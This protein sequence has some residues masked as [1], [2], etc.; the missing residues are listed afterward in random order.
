MATSKRNDYEAG[1][2]WWE[3]TD[4][5]H[6]INRRQFMRQ[7]GT[8]AA[9][10]GLATAAPGFVGRAFAQSGAFPGLPGS[11]YDSDEEPNTLKQ[12]TNKNNFYELGVA[13]SQ[14]PRNIQGFT[15][16]PWEISIGG[17]IAKPGTFDVQDL[18]ARYRD[19]L[20]Q[21]IYRLRC[22]EKWAMVIPWVG[23]PLHELI[24]DYGPTSRAKYLRFE[25]FW[26][27]KQM[28][29]ARRGI[30]YPYIEGLRMDEAMHDLTLVT[31][32]MYGDI[33]DTAN[34]PP[35]RIIVPWKYGY[36]SIKS[37]NKIEFVEEEPVSTWTAAAP[38]EYG[39]Y[40]N[41]NPERAHPRWS[42][43][44]ENR[45]GVGGRR[46]TA[47]FNGYGEWVA[48]LYEGMDLIKYH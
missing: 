31:V 30:H 47:K 46:R 43:R 25:T 37:I 39:F 34:G 17:H 1:I 18:I 24:K 28:P 45:I 40:S 7:A 4:R 35:I 9:G 44:F 29:R 16:S 42:Q 14:R 10:V 32:G 19:K 26:D 13:S 38:H 6:F 41:V 21:R 5:E 48:S 2:K 23:F 27:P 22:V 15:T 20:E 33:L 11:I 36:K 12:A 8:V 3:I